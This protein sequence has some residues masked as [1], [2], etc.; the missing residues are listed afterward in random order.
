MDSNN[1][2]ILNFHDFE[3][4]FLKEKREKGTYFTIKPHQEVCLARLEEVSHTVT[5]ESNTYYQNFFIIYFV[6]DGE[7][8]KTNQLTSITLER[9]CLF[10][11]QP[12]QLNSWKEIKNVSGYI[13]AFTKNFVVRR[14]TD[15]KFLRKLDFFDLRVVPKFRLEQEVSDYY[16]KRFDIALEDYRSKEGDEFIHL[17]IMELLLRTQKECH[18]GSLSNLLNRNRSRAMKICE[19]FKEK[20]EDHY[21]EGHKQNF[22]PSKRVADY[23]KDLN[24]N[25]NYLNN[26]V[27]EAYGKKASDLIFE[28]TLLAA[29][30]KLIH[31][32]KTISEIAFFLDFNSPSYFVRF[33]KERARITPSQYRN[34]VGKFLK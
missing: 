8:E 13:L 12:G 26:M 20:I 33:F 23:A 18:L 27:K 22:I 2:T 32:N 9:N 5:E 3:T 29:Q 11:T 24:I 6:T 14:L 15:K 30:S 7:I 17:W 10:F 4:F 25:A 28:R 19:D 31:T 16:Q 21:I 1:Y 34:R